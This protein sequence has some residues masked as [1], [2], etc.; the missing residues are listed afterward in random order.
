MT[1]HIRADFARLSCTQHRSAYRDSW[2]RAKEA[3]KSV[4]LFRTVDDGVCLV[5]GRGVS[6]ELCFGKGFILWRWVMSRKS[7]VLLTQKLLVGDSFDQHVVS[8][9]LE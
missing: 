8:I 2:Q 9:G 1:N 3:A 5:Q 4:V 6:G 7:K